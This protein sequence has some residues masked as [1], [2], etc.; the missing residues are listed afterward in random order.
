MGSALTAVQGKRRRNWIV[1]LSALALTAPGRIA[2]AEPAPLLGTNELTHL[3]RALSRL[4]MDEADLG[5][6]KD[7][8]KP[9]MALEWVRHALNHPLD[10][11]P[12]ADRIREAAATNSAHKLWALAGDL[13]EAAVSARPAPVTDESLACSNALNPHLAVYL[14][15]FVDRAGGAADLFAAASQE[16]GTDDMQYASAVLLGD[17]FDSEDRPETRAALRAA[18]VSSQAVAQAI[19]DGKALDPE[20][21]QKRIV[22]LTRRLKLDLALAAGEAF[23]DAVVRLSRQAVEVKAWP[24]KPVVLNTRLG[25]VVVGTPGDD[26]YTN[27]AVL[28]LEPGGD[29]RYAGEAAAANGLK[30]QRLAAV[31]DMAG[32]DRYDGAGLMGPGGALFGLSILLDLAGDDI[33]ETAYSGQGAALFGAAWLEDAAGSDLYK[34]RGFAQGAAIAGLGVL[35]DGDGDDLYTVGLAGQA[36]A[37]VRGAGFL[38]DADG[39]DRYLAGNEEPDWERYEDRFVSLAQGF[40]IGL[41]PFA[42]GGVAAL[43][44]LK[45]NDTYVADVYGQ[46]VSYWY[47]AGF[48]L[49]SA[50]NDTYRVHQYGQGS[51]IHLSLGL[52]ADYGGN[53]V[54]SGMGLVQG[55][56]HDYAVGML[57]DRAGNDIY[58]AESGS[59]GC[60]INNGFALLLDGAGNDTYFGARPELCQGI[61]N[62]G[63]PRQYGSLS[64]LMDLGGTDLYSCG[65]TNNG[66]L[67]RPSFGIVYDVE[68][69]PEPGQEAKK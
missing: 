28:I 45:G 1:L 55:C 30:G 3:H 42:G 65:A 10:L 64:I 52:L 15:E 35:H 39:N 9:V 63:G 60:A 38:V 5:F 62:D 40:A 69:A 68:T 20:P 51:G 66:M 8:A 46:G 7:I 54:Y 36:Y 56:S 6:E 67:V 59:Q 24:A 37:G 44:D 13:L 16:L 18:G 12:V 23:H 41:R 27:G 61:G 32:N 33:Y 34:A 49:D 48:L 22:E 25:P 43:V 50:G 29:D 57:F 31:V 58:T 17:L 53:D 26:V 2:A 14:R 47:S 4:N 19:E 11:P 21:S